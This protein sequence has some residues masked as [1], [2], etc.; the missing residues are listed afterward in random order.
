LIKDRTRTPFNIGEGIV[1]RDLDRTDAAVLQQGL[2]AA[3]PGQGQ[4]ILD[5]VFYWTAGHPYLTQKLC[6]EVVE[7]KHAGPWT[8]AEV[9]RVVNDL[10]LSD[11]ANRE[12]NLQFV[13]DR[14]LKNPQR[15][16]LLKLYGKVRAGKVIA[17]DE[18]SM[19]QNQLKLAGLITTDDGNLRVHNE[20]YR[21]VFDAKWIKANTPRDSNRLVAY[22][23]IAVATLVVGLAGFVLVYNS[24]VQHQ[25]EQLQLEFAQASTAAD[26]LDRL[27]Q[28]F[29]LQGILNAT[30]FDDAARQEFF[31]LKDRQAQ[32]DL[33]QVQDPRIVSVIKGL[34][35][36]L[37][38]TTL[39]EADPASGENDAL[40]VA[41]KSALEQLANPSSD[42][43]RLR[44]EIAL[45]LQA[46]Q[47]AHDQFDKALTDYTK[48]I[49]LND[50]N[51]AT[52]YERAKILIKLQPPLY[53]QASSDLDTVI[54][55]ARKVSQPESREQS[56]II[57]P[58][59]TE[60]TA[61]P[62]L[63]PTGAEL[64]KTPVSTINVKPG[65]TAGTS[66]I[67]GAAATVAP[68]RQASTPSSA[69][70][71]PPRLDAQRPFRSDFITFVQIASAVKRLIDS[72]PA[73]VGFLA[74][75]TD[76]DFG[77]LWGV[78]LV[79]T[80]TPTP[81]LAK[82]E[83]TPRPTSIVSQIGVTP[84]VTPPLP[85]GPGKIGL[86]V[87]LGNRSG[88]NDFLLT[89]ANAGL[90]VPVVVAMDQNVWDDVQQHSPQT[91]VVFRDSLSSGQAVRFDPFNPDGTLRDPVEVAQ[92]YFDQVNPVWSINKANYYGTP[93]ELS[94]H[95]EWESAFYLA[96][97]EIAETHGYKLA[98]DFTDA[99]LTQEATRAMLP[100]LQRAKANGHILILHE[101]SNIEADVKTPQALRYRD[102][103]EST[104]IPNNA[105]P[106][107]V[108]IAGEDGGI[109]HLDVGTL[110]DDVGWYNSE[111]E[112]DNYVIGAALWT[113]GGDSSINIST[114]LPELA[115]YIS[116]HPAPVA[117][118]TVTLDAVTELFR[119]TNEL[120][121][122]NK[123]S[124]YSLNP[125]LNQVA[126]AH[127]QD[128]ATTGQI[129][130][131]GSDGSTATQRITNAGYGAGQPAENI[132]GGAATVDDAW[133]FWSIDPVHL[134]NLLSFVNTDI[135]IGVAQ[136]ISNTYYTMVFGKPTQVT[137]VTPTPDPVAE[138]LARINSLR[139]NNKLAPY[140]LNTDLNQVALAHSQDMANVDQLTDIGSD[141][142]TAEQRIAAAG[143]G[144]GQP[145]EAI[146]NGPGETVDGAWG[147]LT[148]D[149]ADLANLLNAVNMDVGI[150]VAQNQ[151]NTYYT[152]TFGKAAQ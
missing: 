35:T 82:G 8:E 4:A 63:A 110:I 55:A 77:N 31:T 41:M 54:A 22:A 140:T 61:I 97:M 113:L 37:A 137:A 85:S 79:R 146:C 52:H 130:H 40:L 62:T 134:A 74:G 17:N 30:N 65:V 90:P 67:P 105:D 12:Q 120:R 33:L 93:D 6:H 80:L 16:E 106:P 116:S 122:N 42:A 73:L 5:R 19:L 2:E 143:Y 102:W 145:A 151:S 83:T 112:K 87:I 34:Y 96:L 118:N 148:A 123:L 135:G 72:K 36:A 125:E 121:Q 28:L 44:D 32:L 10:F 92:Q 150:G 103:Y 128:M 48:A 27:A 14:V 108:V 111:I 133:N 98:L 132:Y 3:Y 115:D 119:R 127:S 11:Q 139:A 25:A 91:L 86:H 43:V 46:R 138:L 76:S 68:P 45:W 84:S 20:I 142:S 24:N 95:W 101:F 124:P 64:P 66:R 109:K 7:A 23:A 81:A 21:V 51:P 136:S 50:D 114:V 1:L 78:Q 71:Q 26:R 117:A 15:R 13:Q 29:D 69:A 152:I 56:T 141:G 99:A 144:A 9:D 107:L 129:T 59:L 58:T 18:Q 94:G 60:S 47:Y 70:S 49:D 57:T 131:V 75:S 39:T 149:S 100:T 53:S 126:L 88:F 147:K 104:L 38:D 89:T